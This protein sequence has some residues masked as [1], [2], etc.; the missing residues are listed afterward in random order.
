MNAHNSYYILCS[1]NCLKFLSCLAGNSHGEIPSQLQLEGS[2]VHD[3]P[4][5]IQRKSVPYNISVGPPLAS[6]RM[7]TTLSFQSRT[8]LMNPPQHSNHSDTQES[9]VTSPINGAMGSSPPLETTCHSS[10]SLPAN[11]NLTLEVTVFEKY[12]EKLCSTIT[13]ITDL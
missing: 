9:T 8:S 5:I 1:S 7:D 11:V 13:D 10:P 2:H 6:S 3:Q 12:Y 4:P